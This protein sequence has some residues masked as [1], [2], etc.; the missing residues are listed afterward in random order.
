MPQR[1]RRPPLKPNWLLI[2]VLLW[3]VAFWVVVAM[4]VTRALT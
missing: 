4:V 2:L 1:R 3:Q